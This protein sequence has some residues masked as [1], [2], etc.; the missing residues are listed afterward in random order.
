[1]SDKCRCKC[2]VVKLNSSSFFLNIVDLPLMQVNN[3][4]KIFLALGYPLAETKKYTYNV[5]K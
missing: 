4:K 3:V 2:F 5:K 1:M